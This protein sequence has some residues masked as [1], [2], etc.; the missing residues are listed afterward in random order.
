MGWCLLNKLIIFGID[1]NQQIERL[2]KNLNIS[3]FLDNHETKL[4]RDKK[5]I[6]SLVCTMYDILKNSKKSYFCGYHIIVDICLTGIS[7]EYCFIFKN[8]S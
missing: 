3:Y 4:T 1:H 6:P 8:N 7:M 2:F 5:D